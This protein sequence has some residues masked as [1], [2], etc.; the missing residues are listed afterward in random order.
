MRR[1]IAQVALVVKA[2]SSN[3]SGAVFSFQSCCA[4]NTPFEC[5]VLRVKDKEAMVTDELAAAMD[6][7]EAT[8]TSNLQYGPSIPKIEGQGFQERVGQHTEQ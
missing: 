1:C 2:C 7:L 8:Q 5:A 3:G 6:D 4:K